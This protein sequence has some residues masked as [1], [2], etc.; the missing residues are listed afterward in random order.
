MPFHRLCCLA[1]IAWMPALAQPQPL[2]LEA[3]L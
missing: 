1:A 2:D 3:A